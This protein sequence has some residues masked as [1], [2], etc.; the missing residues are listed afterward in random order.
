[1]W[2]PLAFFAT[3]T[4]YASVGFGGGSTYTAL[5]A[6]SDVDYK[7]IPIVSLSAN[8]IVVAGGTLAFA[9]EG[10]L[11]P[12]LALPLA[13]GSVPMA[14]LGG[15]TPI[16]E[17]SFLT[18][19]GVCLVATAI[20]MALSPESSGASGMERH[21]TAW[22]LG[23]P[24]L[25]GAIGYLSGL[26]GIGGGIFLAP[27]LHLGQVAPPKSVAATASVFIFVNSLAGLGGQLQKWDGGGLASATFTYGPL[28]L[29]VL[30]G[31]RIGSYAS[32]H[33]LHP[34]TVRRLTAILVLYVGVRLCVGAASVM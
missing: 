30:L 26:V 4:L 33:M 31:G 1:M 22:T 7:T 3:A 19:L 28:L 18:V 16:G 8:L 25:G 20:L 6:V 11:R 27:L 32:I 23:S 9:R 24:L 21:P 15:S 10:W 5:L 17:E 13:L 12:R 29:A 14:W 34:T 2:L